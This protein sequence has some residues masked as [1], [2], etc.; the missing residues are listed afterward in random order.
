MIHSSDRWIIDDSLWVFSVASLVVHEYVCCLSVP[1]TWYDLQ[2]IFPGG[3]PYNLNDLLAQHIIT[4]GWH[5]DDLDRAD[6]D[7]SEPRKES[8]QPS[9][10]GNNS[11]S[12]RPFYY[13][14]FVLRSIEHGGTYHSNPKHISYAL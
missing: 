5:P 7:L 1:G 8:Y 11:A 14:Y 13:N 6:R 3:Q 2:P 10:N 12:A 9:T 4:T